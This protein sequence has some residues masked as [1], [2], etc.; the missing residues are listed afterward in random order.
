MEGWTTS[1]I[2]SK[3]IFEANSDFIQSVFRKNYYATNSHSHMLHCHFFIP[4]RELSQ[5]RM[6]LCMF[7]PPDTVFPSSC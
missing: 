7:F 4:D 3:V 6:N 2:V 5:Y 1:S